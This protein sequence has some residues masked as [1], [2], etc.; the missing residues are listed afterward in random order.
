MKIVI[1]IATQ[2][3]RKGTL[4]QT[5]E[6]LNKQTV[7]PDEI[8]IYNND[9]NE[10]DATDN[11]KFYY[12]TTEQSKEET[13]LFLSCD[14]DIL[15]PTD[16]IEQ[17]IKAVQ[18]YGCIISFHGRVLKGENRDYYR[19]HSMFS[20]KDNVVYQDN[21]DVVGTGVT[22]FITDYFKPS[23][24]IFYND[25]KRMSDLLF[26]LEAT[27]AGKRMIMK[28]HKKGWLKDICDDLANSC[29]STELGNKTQMLL[30]NE[31][32]NNKMPLVSIVI[33]YNKD[34]GYLE[35]AKESIRNLTYPNIEVIEHC[36]DNSFG[37]N[38]NRCVEKC[39]GQYI[40]YL[41]DDDTLPKDAIE[42]SLLGFTDDSIDFI[43]GKSNIFGAK[44]GIFTPDIK[45]PTL[46]QMLVQNRF[47]GGTVM[48]RARVFEKH[49]YDETLWTGEEYD[50]NLK[51]LSEGYKVGYSD[52][53]LYNYRRHSEQKSL[54]NL[55]K[56][57]QNKRKEAIQQIK[58]RYDKK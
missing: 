54:G 27:K 30:A 2:E 45:Q 46:Q 53:I 44:K 55:D 22:A 39:K 14:D 15:Y 18:Y 52:N 20:F 11:G 50:F 36:S 4:T 12:F 57:Y 17:V 24:D 48:Y 35:E 51:L 25:H 34:R 42:K 7:K 58:N 29:F 37:Y 38:M 16:Y 23:E 43:N 32:L 41:Q 21:L 8:Y 26:S 9:E 40:T 5:L 13:V 6:S 19:G 49:K 47:N 1:G 56:E 3:V 28:S 31:I 10:F 33:P